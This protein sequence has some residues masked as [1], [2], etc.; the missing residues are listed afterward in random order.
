MFD[1]VNFIFSGGGET[2]YAHHARSFWG[3]LQKILP[4]KD[5]GKECSIVLGCVNDPDFYRSIEGHKIAYNVWESTLYPDD[6][7][8]RLLDFDQLWVP[9]TWQR[10][11]AIDQGYPADRVKIVPEGVD[12]ETFR[13]VNK[14]EAIPLRGPTKAF[15]FLVFGRWE[16]RKST[17]E[18]IESFR[19]AF[20]KNE[21]VCLLLSVDNPFPVDKYKMTDERLEAYG[22]LP[23]SRIHNIGF[24]S[25]QE[26]INILR[27]GHV[28]VS[29]ARAEGWNLPLIEALACGTPSICSDYGAQLDFAQSAIKVKIKEHKKP[30]NVYNMPDCPGTVWGKKGQNNVSTSL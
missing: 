21:D 14:K 27:T 10:Q 12:G 8:K 11:C 3:E 7:F 28:F 9:T 23:D 29:C 15:R 17:K 26:Y 25:R 6:F 2:G 30:I 13:P 22:L 19:K 1:K 24:V 4:Q 5:G 16:D 20:V 18:I